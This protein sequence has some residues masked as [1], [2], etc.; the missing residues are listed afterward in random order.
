MVNFCMKVFTNIL[1]G[2][3]MIVA[4]FL[5]WI[6]SFTGI[7]DSAS[8]VV[9]NIFGAIGA[10]T[11]SAIALNKLFQTK[12]DKRIKEVELEIAELE[13]KD[14]KK[15]AAIAEEQEYLDNLNNI[16]I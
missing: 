14:C 8:L 13:L 3:S 2:T 7:I 5:N 6:A 1:S 4:L 10:I 12:T 15:K 9:I 11:W 16:E